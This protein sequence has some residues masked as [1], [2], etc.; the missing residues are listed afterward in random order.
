MA[1]PIPGD[2]RKLEEGMLHIKKA[3]SFGQ[4]GMLALPVYLDATWVFPDYA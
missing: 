3:L 4:S 1:Y 2:C